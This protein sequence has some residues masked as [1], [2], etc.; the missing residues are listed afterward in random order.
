MP[1]ICC[2]E[3]TEAGK[4][5]TEDD[6]DDV[7]DE[8]DFSGE[9]RST[10]IEK[11]L[12][13]EEIYQFYE[14]ESSEYLDGGASRNKEENTT[15]S[16][17]PD[18]TEDDIMKNMDPNEVNGSTD[19]PTSDDGL[20]TQNMLLK[21]KLKEVED[22]FKDTEQKTLETETDLIDANTEISKLKDEND[23]L[24]ED[25]KLKEEQNELLI[26]EKNA[27][28]EN[29]A[30]ANG[31]VHKQ[32][33]ERNNMQN[34]IEKLKTTLEL[35]KDDD[36]T[37]VAD[38]ELKA[39]LKEKTKELE[40]A[41]KDKKQLAKDLAEAQNKAKN[42]PDDDS[43]KCLKL[44]SLLKNQK[45]ESKKANEEVKRLTKANTDMEKCANLQTM[46]V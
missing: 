6:L 38:K 14:E 5:E 21:S 24:K 15:A 45:A 46:F 44:T 33:T 16:V 30:R 23:V 1:S 18:D 31:I 3:K 13:V 20:L 37:T 4:D 19:E 36:S 39:K 35:A 42:E 8:F 11:P 41:N 34:V 26:G 28:E 9:V 43:E 32:F 25:M 22:K 27:L 40:Q 10:Q 2:T 7:S 29:V 12:N 17:I